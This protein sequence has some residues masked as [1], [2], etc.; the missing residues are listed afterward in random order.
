M[1]HDAPGRDTLDPWMLSTLVVGELYDTYGL[2]TQRTRQEQMCGKLGK[3]TCRKQSELWD[4][5][6]KHEYPFVRQWEDELHQEV[7]HGVWW[8]GQVRIQWSLMS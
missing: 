6:Y 2:V 4:V 5:G 3:G 7:D 8:W 1:Y